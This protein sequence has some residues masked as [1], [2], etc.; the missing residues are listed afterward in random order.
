MK[1]S[2]VSK[3]CVFQFIG[4][5]LILFTF[6][7][8]LFTAPVSAH[9]FH[10]SLTRIDYNSEEKLFEISI[11]LFT[12]DLIPLLEQRSGKRVDLEKTL[13]VDKIILE[14]L[15]ENFVLSDKE[16]EKKNLKWVGK[17]SDIDS[18]RIY[19]ET[20]SNEN[21]ENYKLKNTIFFES[22]REQTNLVVCRYDGKKADLMFKVGD[23]IKEI[24]EVRSEKWE[25]F[26]D[27]IALCHFQPLSFQF[28][29][30]LE[31]LWK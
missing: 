24:K 14:Y 5:V 29:F 27:N 28:K 2:L 21:L 3:N 7:F 11:Q 13:N 26:A 9:R 15:N 17:E 22:F 10:T 16:G 18:V 31:K 4:F 6:H 25:M 19:L 23:K 30:L 12:H 1:K 8:S 20:P